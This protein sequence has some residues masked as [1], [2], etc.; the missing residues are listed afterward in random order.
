LLLFKLALYFC[1]P[2][3]RWYIRWQTR[4]GARRLKAP[5]IRWTLF[6]D[7]L[8]T[9]SSQRNRSLP[10]TDL[11]KIDAFPHSWWLH[12]KQA[13]SFMAPVAVLTPEVQAFLRLKAA[14]GV[15]EQ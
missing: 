5:T 12:F 15:S 10:W 2:F 3:T 7:R 1:P 13:D 8:E 6:E 9:Q 4:R 14:L 11:Q